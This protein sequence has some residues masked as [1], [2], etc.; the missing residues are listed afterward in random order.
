MAGRIPVVK[1]ALACE[2]GEASYAHFCSF[3]GAF[4]TLYSVLVRAFVNYSHSS[5]HSARYHT[6][7]ISNNYA[8]C[9]VI[10]RNKVSCSA[11][12]KDLL[13]LAS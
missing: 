3:S 2:L 7:R 1:G 5:C 8:L 4:V 13:A 12:L 10:H 9:Y 6:R 11:P